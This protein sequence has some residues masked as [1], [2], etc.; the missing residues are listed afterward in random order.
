MPRALALALLSSIVVG[1]AVDGADPAVD[2]PT[3][4]IE[5]PGVD[6]K[7]PILLPP[8]GNLGG[9]L[10]VT[11][12]RPGISELG[13]AEERPALVGGTT[14]RVPIPTSAECLPTPGAAALRVG[15]ALGVHFRASAGILG[16]DL[17]RVRLVRLGPGPLRTV[18]DRTLPA[19][20][21]TAEEGFVP[22]ATETEVGA[23]V[24]TLPRLRY[25]LIVEDAAGREARAGLERKLAPAPAVAIAGPVEVT[26]P[27]VSDGN[28]VLSAGFRVRNAE[29][30]DLVGVRSF[31]DASSI[32]LGV[33]ESASTIVEYGPPPDPLRVT[34]SPSESSGRMC[35]T[36]FLSGA[37][38]NS[39]KSARLP[40]RVY[41]RAPRIEGCQLWALSTPIEA[42]D[43]TS[44]WPTS[45][46]GRP[47]PAPSWPTCTNHGQ[48]GGAVGGGGVV[49]GPGTGSTCTSE[50]SPCEVTPS[51]CDATINPIKVAG[52]IRCDGTRAVCE[53]T[54]PYCPDTAGAACG[55]AY[56][57]TCRRDEDCGPGLFC[58]M[59]VGGC[60]GSGD[61]VACGACQHI[62][63]R[64]GSICT[65]PPGL[66]WLPGSLRPGQGCHQNTCAPQCDGST[67]G[68][69]G[70]GGVC[71][72]CKSG[73]YCEPKPASPYG[74]T[75]KAI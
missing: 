30:V 37:A 48:G 1:C 55:G 2:G 34:P 62:T 4:P 74:G 51:G 20:T 17:R 33:L 23:N 16:S 75:C 31:G 3:G 9:D 13:I 18:L 49:V 60:V 63:Y 21:R 11:L 68:N 27:N 66:C 57:E 28:R 59:R 41:A 32:Q 71:G 61:D 19:G 47:P 53:P 12:G 52:K 56:G 35:D 44:P 46:D 6:T 5:E 42:A 54:A 14:A 70:C 39:W 38:W 24:T 15:G 10:I 7:G 43:R 72:T 64:D 58:G 69:D 73:Q 29:V 45:T 8:P 67:C 26:G 25:E 22:L 40:V 36:Q 50:G 65:P